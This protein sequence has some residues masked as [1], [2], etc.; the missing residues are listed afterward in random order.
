MFLSFGTWPRHVEALVLRR[1]VRLLMWLLVLCEFAGVC[2]RTPNPS[3]PMGIMQNI[4]AIK[5]NNV[6][7]R[8]AVEDLGQYMVAFLKADN[9]PRLLTYD[10]MVF[11]QSDKYELKKLPDE[12]VWILTV[13]NVQESDAG[14]YT[15]QINTMPVMGSTGYLHLKIPPFVSR[16]STPSAVEVREGHNVTLNCEATGNP[17]PTV[18]WRR[19]DRQVIRYNGANGFG[20]SFYNG[21]ELFIMRV[22]RKHM[23][24]YVCIASNGIPP[25]ETWTVKLHVTFEPVVTPQSL[26]VESRQGTVVRLVCTVEAWPRPM[27]TWLFNDVEVYDPTRYHTETAVAERYKSVH[28]LE[29]RSV[30]KNSFGNYRCIASNEYGKNY[31]DIRLIEAAP[32]VTNSIIQTEGVASHDPDSEREVAEPSDNPDDEQTNE[33]DYN[34]IDGLVNRRSNHQEAEDKLRDLK[35]EDPAIL[36]AGSTE[37][38]IK[39]LRQAERPNSSSRCSTNIQWLSPV[40]LFH[41]SYLMLR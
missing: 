41:F 34:E 21:S 3:F 13:R 30:Q 24:E 15:C 2:V 11:R 1:S 35:V 8:C 28:V 38:L 40:L 4:T 36:D 14:G 9:P 37:E 12:D 27:V 32:L 33:I 26:I 18:I 29:I 10:E 7:F 22:N 6:E 19:K 39:E 17:T 20:A 16:S 25:D 23:S 31:S 5:G